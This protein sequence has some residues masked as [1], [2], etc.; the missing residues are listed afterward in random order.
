MRDLRNNFPYT[1][2]PQKDF[3]HRFLFEKYIFE[4]YE[5]DGR[6]IA[7]A[8]NLFVEISFKTINGH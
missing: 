6:G 7:K 4:K 2:F 3:L 1:L 8:R 5:R